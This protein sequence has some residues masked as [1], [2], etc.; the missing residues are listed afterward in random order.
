V[1]IRN[2]VSTREHKIWDRRA[3]PNDSSY[4]PGRRYPAYVEH[5][6]PVPA[7]S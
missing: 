4:E 5:E 2:Y 3:K 1:T 6:K 7:R